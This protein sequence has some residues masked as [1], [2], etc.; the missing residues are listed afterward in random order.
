MLILK[1]V[2]DE[3][4]PVSIFF[5]WPYIRF[6]AYLNELNHSDTFETHSAD[7]LVEKLKEY[8]SVVFCSK[9]FSY[10]LVVELRTCITNSIS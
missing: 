2:P 3:S 1:F 9:C 7:Y 8:F 4:R 10:R 5:S 6:V